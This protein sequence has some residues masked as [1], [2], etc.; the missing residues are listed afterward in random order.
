MNIWT[1]VIVDYFVAQTPEWRLGGSS[2]ILDTLTVA[3]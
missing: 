2:S 3:S 1:L